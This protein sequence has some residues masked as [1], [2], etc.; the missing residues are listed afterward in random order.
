MSDCNCKRKPTDALVN[1]ENNVATISIGGTLLKY[2]LKLIGFVL[3]VCISPFIYLYMIWM[4]FKTIVLNE[5]VDI[6]PLLKKLGSKF[7]EEDNDIE[8]DYDNLTEA[9]VVLMNAE[10]I[11]K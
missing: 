6:R 4:M 8:N 1:G 5:S 3:A 9:D 7:K 11:S 10:E 2:T